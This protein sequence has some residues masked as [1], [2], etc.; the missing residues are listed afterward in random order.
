MVQVFEEIVLYYRRFPMEPGG[1]G[2]AFWNLEFV[3]DGSKLHP[4][5]RDF[6]L[7]S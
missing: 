6:N 2:C 1:V 7:K 4:A 5:N 3:G